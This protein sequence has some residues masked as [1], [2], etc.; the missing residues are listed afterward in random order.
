[1]KPSQTNQRLQ[2]FL[3]KKKKNPLRLGNTNSIKTKAIGVRKRK[4]KGSCSYDVILASIVFIIILLIFILSL[5]LRRGGSSIGIN[6]LL[7]SLRSLKTVYIGPEL[8]NL[9]QNIR[10]FAFPV[11]HGFRRVWVARG[12]LFDLIRF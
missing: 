2:K 1:M 8:D 6:L 10:G 7:L 12:E 11:S 3:P 4:L 5:L 9:V